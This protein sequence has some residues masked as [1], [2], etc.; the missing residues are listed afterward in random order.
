[1]SASLQVPRADLVR[2]IRNATVTRAVIVRKE[3]HHLGAVYDADGALVRESLRFPDKHRARDPKSLAMVQGL[4]IERRIPRAL[5]LGHAFTHFGHFLIETV[6]ALWWARQVDD[7]VALI[8]HPFDEAGR[9]VFAE[10]SHGRDCLTLL[11]LSPDRIVM[12]TDGLAVEELLLPPRHYD[13]RT[14]PRYDFREIY[15]TLVAAARTEKSPPPSWGRVGRGK[16]RFDANQPSL[17]SPTPTRPH[18]GG[19]GTMIFLSRRQLKRR[20]RRLS[21][22]APVER[23]MARRGFSVAHPQLMSL[24]EQIN[25][26][27]GADL[28]AGVDGSALHLSVFMRPG[29]RMLVLQTKRRRTIHFMNALMEVETISVPVHGASVPKRIDLSELDRTLDGLGCPKPG[30]VGRILNLID[31]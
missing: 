8:F 23:R 6:P 2:H 30:P 17:A 31:R 4:K 26:A 14:G 15:R 19:G 21:N 9:N 12:A 18:V 29:A 20:L 1:M 3:R 11:G 25:A 28:I 5:Y 13:M 27:A 16:P 24:A 10:T 22:D 7:D